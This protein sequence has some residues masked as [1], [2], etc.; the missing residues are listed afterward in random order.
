MMTLEN[1]SASHHAAKIALNSKISTD[2][3][4]TA[5]LESSRGDL[6]APHCGLLILARILVPAGQEMPVGT[7][8]A[9]GL[10][11]GE[12]LAV[13]SHAVVQIAQQEMTTVPNI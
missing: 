9:P 13:E 8:L 7:V 12:T 6:T 11:G 5:S 1:P 2:I 10:A 4:I 3:V